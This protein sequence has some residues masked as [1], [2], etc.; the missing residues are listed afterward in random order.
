MGPVRLN[1]L[2]AG[3]GDAIVEKAAFRL[4]DIDPVRVQ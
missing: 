1:G 3:D 4:L 2:L